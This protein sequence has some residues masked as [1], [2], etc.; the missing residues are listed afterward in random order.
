[1]TIEQHGLS[2]KGTE[3]RVARIPLDTEQ[4]EDTEGHGGGL[5]LDTE[6]SGD[7]EDTAGHSFRHG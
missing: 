1:M 6:Q 5:P 2:T 3:G 7:D 4:P